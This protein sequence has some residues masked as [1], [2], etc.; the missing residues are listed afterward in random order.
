MAIAADAVWEVRTDG[1]D[2]NGGAFN[3]ERAGAGVDYTY[4]TPQVFAY[5]DLEI[6]G[7]DNT[8]I[9]SSARA[10]V[11]DDVGNHLRVTAGT[12]FTVGT[13][14]IVSVSGG[15]A[16]LDRAVG[17]TGST[18]GSGNLGGALAGPVAA[19]ARMAAGNTIWLKGGPADF[20][21]SDMFVIPNSATPETRPY[22]IEGYGE[23]RGDG[24]RAVIR[25]S[26]AT[27][28]VQVNRGVGFMAHLL[29]DADGNNVT[30]AVLE[31]GSNATSWLFEDVIARGAAGQEGLRAIGGRNVYRDCLF[32]GNGGPGADLRGSNVGNYFDRCVFRGNGE[33]GVQ[34]GAAFEFFSHCLFVGNDEDGMRFAGGGQWAFLNCVFRKN[35]RDGLR[36]AAT[37]N[38]AAVHNC[39]FAENV[40]HGISD[41]SIDSPLELALHARRFLHNA[42]Y[43]NGEGPRDGVVEGIGEITLT[44]DPFVDADNGDFRLNN[45]AGGG[46]LLRGAAAQEF[47][48]YPLSVGGRDIGAVQSLVVAV[49][50][51]FKGA[52][53]Y[54]LGRG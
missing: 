53:F 31:V 46:A 50:A 43:N 38:L 28:M 19:G 2:D 12:G 49:V 3:P 22:H 27:R 39:I 29:L 34:S 47:G 44:A 26:T 32:E 11:A 6:D 21:I 25:A 24:E 17:S 14:E 18:G 41:N 52:F 30:V 16:T 5:T 37:A 4:P 1:S 10:F 35:G 40:G 36:W 20:L 33:E 13:Y 51:A 15:E 54:F 7:S 9:S 8:V 42:F 23:A 48:A 45:A